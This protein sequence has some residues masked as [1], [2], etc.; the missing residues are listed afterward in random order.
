M[1]LI[2]CK[3][4]GEKVSSNASSCPHCGNPIKLDEIYSD[5]EKNIVTVKTSNIA[6]IILCLFSWLVGFCWYTIIFEITANKI[7]SIIP[8][9]LFIVISL[10]IIDT[11]KN[12]YITLTNRRVKG[13]VD[14]LFNS[15]EIDYPLR[16]IKKVSTFGVFGISHF[17]ISNGMENFKIICAING[18]KFKQEYFKLIENKY[19]Y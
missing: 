3:E 14:R 19:K 15:I 9:I 5:I 13:K 10:I 16:Q 4:C 18:K 12:T 2:K 11:L 8:L 17:V 7:Y 6:I 1:S